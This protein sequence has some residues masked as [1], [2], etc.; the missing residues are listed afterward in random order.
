MRI[1]RILLLTLALPFASIGHAT[2]YKCIDDAGRPTYTNDRSAG[3]DCSPLNP[4]LPVSSISLP[5]PSNTTPSSAPAAS[6]GAS[7]F[8]KVAPNTQRTRDDARRRILENELDAE[9]Q[10]LEQAREELSVRESGP[11]GRTRIQA[12]EDKVDLH[13]RNV[14]ALEREISGLK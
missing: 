10:A 2:V 5:T 11:T 4:D 12:F 9:R 7:T 14:D 6:P 13:E 8:P 3:R 1:T